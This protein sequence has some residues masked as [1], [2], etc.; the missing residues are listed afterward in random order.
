LEQGYQFALD[1]EAEAHLIT[2]ACSAQ[3]E[4]TKAWTPRLLKINMTA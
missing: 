4:G 3:P 2:L 1:R